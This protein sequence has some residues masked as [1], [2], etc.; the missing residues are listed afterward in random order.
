MGRRKLHFPFVARAF[1]LHGLD[2]DAPVSD[3][4]YIKQ[5]MTAQLAA[6][7]IHTVQ[8]VITHATQFNNLFDVAESW[9]R[10]LQ[11]PSL[12]RCKECAGNADKYLPRPFNRMAFNALA[13]VLDYAVQNRLLWENPV[14]ARLHKYGRDNV[15]GVRNFL[16]NTYNENDRR[17]VG[18]H[19]LTKA[20]R[21][22]A[23]KQSKRACDDCPNCVWMSAS[24]NR[25]PGCVPRNMAET[26]GEHAAPHEWYAHND[27]S[28]DQ[29]DASALGPFVKGVGEAGFM[30]KVYER[31]NPHEQ[32]RRT[33]AAARTN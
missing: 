23:C 10:I 11:S 32:R 22:C 6:E 18:K 33:R 13:D 15:G 1:E 8:D 5:E 24:G 4:K 17:N 3:L 20:A 14:R 2:W 29:A 25:P 12:H 28:V 31:G 30:R 7:D 27:A 9:A 16:V 21:T 19:P 26:N